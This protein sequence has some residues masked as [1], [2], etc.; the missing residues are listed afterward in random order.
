M[1]PSTTPPDL[2]SKGQAEKEPLPTA[3]DK[4]SEA[5]KKAEQTPVF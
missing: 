3:A 1:L 5:G 2:S 4:P